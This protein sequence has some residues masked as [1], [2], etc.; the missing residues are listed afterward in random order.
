MYYDKTKDKNF[1]KDYLNYVNDRI[2]RKYNLSESSVIDDVTTYKYF[3]EIN[4][5]NFENMD[6]N[7]LKEF[8]LYKFRKKIHP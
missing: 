3:N 5:N 4:N 2:K 8:E 6:E 1:S 7:E